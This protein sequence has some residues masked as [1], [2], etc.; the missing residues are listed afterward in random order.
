M[1]FVIHG[2]SCA[3]IGV[4]V[5]RNG[6][7]KRKARCVRKASCLHTVLGV[8]SCPLGWAEVLHSASQQPQHR[9]GI[10]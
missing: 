4:L 2:D 9:P 7:Q 3:T 8:L 6:P 10:C 1:F 5:Q